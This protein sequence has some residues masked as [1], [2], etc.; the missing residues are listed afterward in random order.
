VDRL[1]SYNRAAVRTGRTL[2]LDPYAALILYL[3][4]S[5]CKVSDPFQ[6]KHIRIYLAE[7][8]LNIKSWQSRSIDRVRPTPGGQ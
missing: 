1:V 3:T 7:S 6:A 8:F 4:K 2:V 5:E